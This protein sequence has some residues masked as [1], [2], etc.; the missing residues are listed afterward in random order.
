MQ[1]PGA[2]GQ[3]ADALD[4]FFGR[5]VRGTDQRRQAREQRLDVRPEQSAGIEVGQQVLHGQQGV[6]FLG[7]EPQTEQFV[8]PSQLFG[9]GVE[10]IAAG[11]AVMDDRCVQ[12][13]AEINEVAFQGGPGDF[14]FVHQRLKGHHAPVVEHLVELVEAFRLVH[15]THCFS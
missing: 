5:I 6:D 1:L 4:D 7:R 13:V 8:L 11:V 3:D 10:A 15:A 9:G 12:P 14:Q 2:D